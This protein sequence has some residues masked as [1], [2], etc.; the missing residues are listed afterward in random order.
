[1]IFL[2]TVPLKRS[3]EEFW[4]MTPRRFFGL[5]DSLKKYNGAEDKKENRKGF[6]DEVL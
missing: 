3:E 1:M 4:R 5:V 2:A 6:I